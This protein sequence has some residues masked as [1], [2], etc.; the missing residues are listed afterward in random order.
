MLFYSP[1]TKNHGRM[2]GRPGLI[3]VLTD[4]WT[5]F[6][7]YH[8]EMVE[9]TATG[10]VV[11]SRNKVTGTHKGVGHIPVEGGKLVGAPPTGRSFA[12][13]HIHWWRFKDGVIVEH[14]ATRD[15]LEMMEQLGLLPT[16]PA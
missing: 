7:D 8:H 14:Y 1:D 9:I 10:D 16:K 6:P 2:V 13:Q 4:L 12:V 3:R 11:V 15:D 5:M